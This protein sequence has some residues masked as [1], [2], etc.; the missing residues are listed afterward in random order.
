LRRG[1]N[2]RVQDRTP[3]R[4][5]F[6]KR[7]CTASRSLYS[8][9]KG[10]VKKIP[11]FFGVFFQKFSFVRFIPF[12]RSN[13]LFSRVPRFFKNRLFKESRAANA[14]LARSP[15]LSNRKADEGERRDAPSRNRPPTP[16]G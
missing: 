7:V 2:R 8:V 1:L 10:D 14:R 11:K 15:N 3:F 4:R 6:E 16:K 13:V 9:V 12:F 5:R